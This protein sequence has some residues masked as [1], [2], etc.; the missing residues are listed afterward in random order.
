VMLA[1]LPKADL[2]GLLNS[3]QQLRSLGGVLR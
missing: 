1:V 3:L 2:R